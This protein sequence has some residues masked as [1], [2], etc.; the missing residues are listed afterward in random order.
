M[1][2]GAL[3]PWANVV[4]LGMGGALAM[5]GAIMNPIFYI[6]LLSGGWQ[7]YQRFSNPGAVPPNY[8]K[9]STMQRTAIGLGYAG[10]IGSLAFAMDL[11]QSYKKSPE[12]LMRERELGKSWDMR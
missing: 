6:I 3:T 8:Y 2:A 4:G 10:L 9:I 12:R 5:T 1:G 7:T 11:N